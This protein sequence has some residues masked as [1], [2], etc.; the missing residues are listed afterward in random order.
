MHDE[1]HFGH[2]LPLFDPHRATHEWIMDHG[3]DHIAP[4]HYA[5]H[6]EQTLLERGDHHYDGEY[7]REHHTGSPYW[8]GDGHEDQHLQGEDYR[9]DS[10]EHHYHAGDVYGHDADYHGGKAIMHDIEHSYDQLFHEIESETKHGVEH[11]DVE[12][13]TLPLHRKTHDVT[14]PY[15]TIDF[16]DT[17]HDDHHHEQHY[18]YDD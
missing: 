5:D 13:K 16:K 11:H 18:H 14:H 4:H 2:E 17:H 6:D 15:S 9:H 7:A 3:D 10:D 8:R 12:F 1:D